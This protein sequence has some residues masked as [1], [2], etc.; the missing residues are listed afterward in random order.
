MGKAWAQCPAL[1]KNKNE[2]KP[3]LGPACEVQLSLEGF[4]LLGKELNCMGGGQEEP[5]CVQK[6]TPWLLSMVGLSGTRA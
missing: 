3:V 4:T 2:I 5:G 6:G 1:Q